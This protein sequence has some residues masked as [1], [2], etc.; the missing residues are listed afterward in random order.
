MDSFIIEDRGPI[1]E[2]QFYTESGKISATGTHE[3][4]IFLI[5]ASPADAPH[6]RRRSRGTVFVSPGIFAGE[7]VARR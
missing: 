4:K 1:L 7:F 5:R 2:A 6:G 3:N